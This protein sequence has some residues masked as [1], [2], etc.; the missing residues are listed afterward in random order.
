MTSRDKRVRA[1]CGDTVCP[2]VSSPDAS[3]ILDEQEVALVESLARGE[4]ARGFDKTEILVLSKPRIADRGFDK[5]TVYCE[6]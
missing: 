6:H 2:R 4:L 1:F 3:G 5:T